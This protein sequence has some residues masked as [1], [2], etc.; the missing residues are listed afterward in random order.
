MPIEVT[1]ASYDSYLDQVTF[2]TLTSHKLTTDD[3]IKFTGT[4]WQNPSYNGKK[5]KVIVLD[6]TSFA[7]KNIPAPTDEFKGRLLTSGITFT[8]IGNGTMNNGTYDLVTETGVGY[9]G[10]LY[11]TFINPVGA[12]PS[13]VDTAT[14]VSGGTGYA[15]GDLVYVPLDSIPPPAIPSP[16]EI[17][18]GTSSMTITA[19]GSNYPKPS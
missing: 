4:S 1:G 9:G 14:V 3:E 8:P 17:E 10:S 13:Q 16:E 5:Y 12:V 7:I 6:S 18:T 15:I 19:A 2:T 11:L